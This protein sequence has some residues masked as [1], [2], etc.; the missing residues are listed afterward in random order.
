MKTKAREAAAKG[1]T[2]TSNAR[3]APSTGTAAT[4]PAPEL[5]AATSKRD[6][7][8]AKMLVKQ[9]KKGCG[10]GDGGQA[11][12]G[13]RERFDGG[14]G[15]SESGANQQWSFLSQDEVEVILTNKIDG[16]SPEMYTE[17]AVL[18]H[19]KLTTRFQ[20]VSMQ[21]R[22]CACTVYCELVVWAVKVLCRPC[23]HVRSSRSF[24]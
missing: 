9:K 4:A 11:H 23:H 20:E 24:Y 15:R 3:V 5:D 14:G 22:A 19:R 7:R 12:V 6:K 2:E 17:L 18:I 21:R 8:K 16:C 10:G 1:A 13:E